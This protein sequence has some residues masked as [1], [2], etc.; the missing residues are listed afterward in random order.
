M[1]LHDI[2]FPMP[3]TIVLIISGD[4]KFWGPNIGRSGDLSVNK[5]GHVPSIQ[6]GV[7]MSLRKEPFF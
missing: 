1:Q 2:T 6:T 3:V 5:Q 4:Q 7:R